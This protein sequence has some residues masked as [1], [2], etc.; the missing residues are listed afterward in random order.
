MA[1]RDTPFE[2]MNRLFEQMRR[3]MWEASAFEL[4]PSALPRETT[5]A[6]R[7]AGDRQMVPFRGRQDDRWTVDTNLTVEETEEG[8]AVTADLPGFETE[9]LSIRFEEGVLTVEGRSDVTEESESGSRRQSRRVQERVSIPGV[10]D[11]DRIEASYHNGVLEVSL[12]TEEA[13]EDGGHRIDI[14]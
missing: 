5:S 13:H 8:V 9:D 10:V 3:S 7:P 11:V 1:Y 4:E 14:D 12:P 6:D 2:Q